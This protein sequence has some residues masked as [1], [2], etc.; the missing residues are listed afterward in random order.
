M[1]VVVAEM[2]FGPRHSARGRHVYALTGLFRAFTGI[3]A[4]ALRDP[5][6]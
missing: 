1:I 4:L 2:A 3:L 6:P 5:A